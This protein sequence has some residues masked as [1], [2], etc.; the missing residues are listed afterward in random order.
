MQTLSAVSATFTLE[1]WCASHRLAGTAEP[2]IVARLI[3]GETKPA[4]LEQRQRLEVAPGEELK[5]RHVRLLCGDRVFSEA[6][7]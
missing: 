4:T 3:S 6:D 7:N 5:F 1:K 2:K